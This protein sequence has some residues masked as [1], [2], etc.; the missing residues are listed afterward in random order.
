V[1]EAH[2]LRLVAFDAQLARALENRAAPDYLDAPGLRDGREPPREP[3]DDPFGFPLAEGVER[4]ARLAEVDPDLAGALG[5]LDQRGDVEQRLGRDAALPQ[6]GAAQ[7]LGGVHDDRF[8]PELGAAERRR[9][10]ARPAAHHGHVHLDDEIAHYHGRIIRSVG[11]AADRPGAGDEMDAAVGPG[12]QGRPDPLAERGASLVG[13]R[14]A[15]PGRR[16]LTAEER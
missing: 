1:L 2:L 4:H 15:V 3:A 14:H 10:A 11:D 16:R 7:A 6:T 5:V 12:R 8:E 9:V 13:E